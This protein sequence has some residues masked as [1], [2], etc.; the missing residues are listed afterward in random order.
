MSIWITGSLEVRNSNDELEFKVGDSSGDSPSKMRSTE[1]TGSF[2]VVSDPV[3]AHPILTA[4]YGGDPGIAKVGI[5]MNTEPN[6][7]LAVGGDL[8][9]ND[10]LSNTR[11]TV[12]G[13]TNAYLNV[14]QDTNNRAFFF[15]E[16]SQK[17]I[18]IGTKESSSTYFN[19]VIIKSGSMD[20]QTD[21]TA[22]GN[23]TTA[24]IK[25]TG[26]SIQ[27]SDGG[28]PIAWDTDDNVSIGGGIQIVGNAIQA[29]DG[30]I[31]IQ[32]DVDD[33][34]MIAGDLVAG[35]GTIKGPPA[36][37]VYLESSGSINLD[38]DADG[39]STSTLKIRAGT[40]H[41]ELFTIDEVG[42][43]TTIGD[44]SM[45]NNKKITGV[46]N[47]TVDYN[48]NGASG[49]F[50]VKQN[51]TNV[52]VVNN[53]GQ[54][55]LSGDLKLEQNQILSSGGT[56]PISWDNSDSVSLANDLTVSG[57][58]IFIDRTTTSDP[59]DLRLRTHNTDGIEDG[60][61]VGAVYFYGTE[62]GTDYEAMAYILAEADEDFA[63]GTNFGS[64]LKFGTATNGGS[65]SSKM[66]LDNKGNLSVDGNFFAAG[67]IR[68]NGP[69]TKMVSNGRAPNGES[70]IKIATYEHEGTGT[71][72]S[73]GAGSATI[74]VTFIGR[75][76]VSEPGS[77]YIK[78]AIVDL[79]YENDG[80]VNGQQDSPFISVDL[81]S[82]TLEPANNAWTKDDFAITYNTDGDAELW[83]RENNSSSSTIGGARAFAVILG[84]SLEVDTYTQ[85]WV[86]ESSSSWV[87]AITSLGA[88]KYAEYPKKIFHS[89]S[90]PEVTGSIHLKAGSF[91]NSNPNAPV[92]NGSF[93]TTTGNN[94]TTILRAQTDH[95]SGY[96]HSLIYEGSGSGN[97]ND[98]VLTSDNQDDPAGPEEA[99]RVKNDGRMSIPKFQ[100]RI[101]RKCTFT[102][103][104]TQTAERLLDFGDFLGST[105]FTS[106]D[107][108]DTQYTYCWIAPCDGQFD[109]F[110][111]LSETSWGTEVTPGFSN[112]FTLKVYHEERNTAAALSGKTESLSYGFRYRRLTQIPSGVSY[113]PA[114]KPNSY[115]LTSTQL[116]TF[117]KG[118]K[119]WFTLDPVSSGGN[120][121]ALNVSKTGNQYCQF[122]AKFTL[123][124][125]NF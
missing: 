93:I 98:L 42:D 89:I 68:T 108:V 26:N 105:N 47:I 88:I 10:D 35:G 113:Q 14:G 66:E 19:S 40:T 54:M 25:I 41:N 36:G 65:I 12:Q 117:E 73:Q 82:D 5:A 61:N 101:S 102:M 28:T 119:L 78:K 107:D 22:G 45:V 72:N 16:G 106:G 8:S 58:T 92:T 99:F 81:T 24:G 46:S 31:P 52:V 120:Y 18:R 121:N 3:Y 50:V 7:S 95:D 27:A 69:L 55:T 96:G 80:G 124:N 123:D 115:T 37:D 1:I 11:F 21:I 62:N 38:I 60:D 94:D 20:V 74:L 33:E 114:G 71:A 83:V 90:T 91:H 77:E 111:F 122:V 51:G 64:R 56:T 85:P 32:W 43:I 75:Q 87:S 103:N 29:S 86:L 100:Q 30:G 79:W 76:S 4:S 59:A 39:G 118:D 2:E 110:Q 23:I 17:R 48:T 109:G 84:G 6:V 67:S 97:N 49:N 116:V 13:G 57:G 63:A 44:I 70:F 9:L 53:T 125:S 112:S 34:V 15:W 104:T